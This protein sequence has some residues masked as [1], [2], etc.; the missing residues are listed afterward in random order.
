MRPGRGQ[1]DLGFRGR[2]G[3]RRGVDGRVDARKHFLL[4]QARYL[5]TGNEVLHR[6]RDRLHALVFLY[7]VGARDGAEQLGEAALADALIE[8]K[9]RRQSAAGRGRP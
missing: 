3:A 5:D 8:Y 7:L 6:L 4:E 2:A 9:L 1:T